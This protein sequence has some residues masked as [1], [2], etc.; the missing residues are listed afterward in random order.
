MSELYDR[1]KNLSAKIADVSCAT[2]LMHWDMETYMP[3]NAGLFRS[4]QTSTLEGIVHDMCTSQELGE[5]IEKLGQ[6]ASLD[7]TQRKNVELWK[8]SYELAQKLP[9]SFVERQSHQIGITF[10]K[11]IEGREKNDAKEYLTELQKL[12]EIKKESTKLYGYE[13]HPYDS[14]LYLYEEENTVE[15][16]DVLFH[17]VKTRLKPFLD[18]IFAK[19]KPATQ[20]LNQDYTKQSQLDFTEIL[21]QRMGYDFNE[22]RQDVVV[23]PFCT[24]ISPFDVR[25]TTKIDLNCIEPS[26]WGSI[27]E[28]GHALYEQGLPKEEYGMP[29]G[30][31]ISMAVHES[32]SRIWENNVG[33][34]KAFWKHN[35]GL[36]QEHFPKQSAGLTLDGF[37][38]GINA[39]TP[40]LVRIEA[41]ELTYHFHIMIRYEIEKALIGGDIQAVDIPAM[42]SELYMK[43]LHVTPTD[44]KNGFMQDVHWC[45][46]Y[47]GYFP[48]YSQGSFM[49]AQ[50]YAHALK[51]LPDLDQQ[52][53]AG[54]NT[55]FLAWLRENIHKHG[56]FYT[57]KELCEKVT[58][59]ALNFNY[60]MEYAEKKY[61][62]IYGL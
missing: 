17:D 45:H 36:F 29:I 8:K 9:T 12:V 21:L 23:H 25:V 55:Q 20:F 16:L 59:E 3:K 38:K 35:F 27:H 33:R 54:D 31:A 62:E 42:W 15:R 47:F 61:T 51:A 50:W 28:G 52:I 1:L 14:L 11:W 53:A 22:G 46:G 32:Q 60:F 58:G 30:Q 43:Y 4:K 49:S 10:N 26:V 34:G 2:A 19:E 6:D 39:V 18:K 44:M 24:T 7:A 56:K 48:T 57:S 5:L 13:K 37:Y 41:D 40:S